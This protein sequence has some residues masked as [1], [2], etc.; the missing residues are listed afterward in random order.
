MIREVEAFLLTRQWR[1]TRAGLVFELWA[2]SPEGPLRITFTGQEAVMFVPRGTPAQAARRE[3]V[4]L[5]TL[6]G[7]PVDA[8][9]FR[10]ERDLRAARDG[11]HRAEGT[12]FESDIKPV[13]RFL[14]ERFVTGGLRVRGEV[15]AP[16]HAGFL[17]MHDPELRAADDAA[18]PSLRVTSLDIETDGFDGALLSIATITDGVETVLVR[19]DGPADP[20]ISYYSDERAL[21]AAFVDELT[22]D[23]PDAIVGWNVVEYDLRLLA[24]RAREL[25]VPFTLGRAGEHAAVL[26]PQRPTQ[27]H[28][29]RI[30]GRVVLDGIQTLR[31]ATYMFESFRLEDVAALLLGR[32]KAIDAAH[33]EARVAEIRRLHREDPLALADYNLEDCRLVLDIFAHTHLLDFAVER[34]RLTGL[35]MDRPGGSVAAFDHLYLPRLHR[36]GVVAPDIGDVG[37]GTPSPG[38]YVLES[39]PGLYDNVLVLDF[40]SLYPSIIRTFR[41]DPLGL[42]FPGDDPVEG[43]EGARFHRERHILPGL[44]E[45]LWQARDRA[46]KSGDTA[47]STAI[48]ILMNSFYGVLGTPR[49]RFF[50]PR[51]ASSITLRGHEIISRSRTFIEAHHPVIYGDTDSL[52]VL[53]GEGHDERACE[54]IGRRL[55]DELNTFWRDTVAREH[56]VESALEIEYETHYLKFLMPTLRHSERGTKKRYAG[57]V[58]GKDGS[59]RVV[60]KGLEAARTDWTPLARRFQRELFRRVFAGEP[61]KAWVQKVASDV[62]AGVLD[63][64]LV[65]RKRLRRPLDAYAQT[66]APPQVQAARLLDASEGEPREVRYVMTTR[67]PEPVDLHSAPIDHEHYVDKQLAPAADAILHFLGTDFAALAGRQ[68]SLF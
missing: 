67:G 27:P 26:A 60:I 23:D 58:R 1:D 52:F 36:L 51:L 41:I 49:C 33:G 9:Y 44:I 21:L 34:Q 48:K 54:A 10:A 53:I 8:L 14:M 66:G 7:A 30:P 62:R 38:G 15:H 18:P 46:K 45:T 64:E 4:A 61:W 12:A 32:G 65:Y 47:L 20:R 28:V 43:F 29:A 35:S 17:D 59:A 2:A 31:S 42:A 3:T 6:V 57:L 16:P 19:G 56:R 68:M 11:I 13:E 50:D 37:E 24:A 39:R 5:T 63:A 25:G 22:D 40:K 55:A